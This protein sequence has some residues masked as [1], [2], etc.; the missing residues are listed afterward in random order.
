[1]TTWTVGNVKVVRI[2]DLEVD[3]PA[4][5][6]VPDWCVPAFANGRGDVGIAFSTFAIS[7]AGQ[8]IV[9]DPWLAND[10]PRD[11]ADASVVAE[12]LLGAL[13][14]AGFPAEAV[15]V[16]VNTHLDGVGWNTRPAADGDAWIPSF[17]QARYLWSDLQLERH[18]AD[19]RLA[20]L[21]DAGLIDAIAPGDRI[22]DE[23]GVEDAPGH[24]E[25]HLTVRIDSGGETA[26]IPGH[27]FLSPLQLVDPSIAFDVDPASAAA[28]RTKLLTDLA[29]RQG[30]LL[31]PLLG[32]PGG[33]FV[34]RAGAGWSLEVSA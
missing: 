30:L 9:V 13:A 34:R 27:L 31:S 33:G 14:A 29:E 23:V 2:V 32:G 1:V 16:V 10:G 11:R 21:V 7:S 17:P 5:Q 24:D 4:A 28:T 18:L 6:P 12:R 20:P 15:D 3:L 26:A 25:G 8:R 19:D 22:T